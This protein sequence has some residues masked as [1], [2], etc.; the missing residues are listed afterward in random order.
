MKVKKGICGLL[1]VMGFIVVGCGKQSEK[2]ESS[3][4][5]GDNFPLKMNISEIKKGHYESLQGSWIN[6]KGDWIEIQGNTMGFTNVTGISPKTP[7]LLS[8]LKIELLSEEKESAKKQLEG[9]EEQGVAMLKTTS[10]GNTLS[11]FFLPKG[12]VGRFTN[13]TEK[14]KAQ[15]KIILTFSHQKVEEANLDE[16]YYREEQSEE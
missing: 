12:K 6:E 4:S 8:R 14:E 15:E 11:L 9:K 10:D 3:L 13:L 5:T 1:V 2:T 16:I 7:A